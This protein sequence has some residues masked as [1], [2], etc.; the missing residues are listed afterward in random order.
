M[1]KHKNLILK[2]ISKIF[3]KLKLKIFNNIKNMEKLKIFI[4]N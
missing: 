3:L 1:K 2:A 4:K